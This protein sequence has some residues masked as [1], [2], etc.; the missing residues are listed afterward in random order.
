MQPLALGSV[1]SGMSTET[2]A[3]EALKRALPSFRY[4]VKLLCEID[5]KK[6]RFLKSLH[7]HA[8]RYVD[9]RSLKHED[10]L[11]PVDILFAG[12]S[13]K[14]VSRLNMTAESVLSMKGS[15]GQTL[16]GLNGYL[17][18]LPFEQRPRL[19]F[20]ETWPRW[21]RR[22]PSTAT[23]PLPPSSGTSSTRSATPAIGLPPAPKTFLSPSTA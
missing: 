19:L 17:G 11:P 5:R 10:G 8:K 15:T 1:C 18:A 23:R 21:T 13:C 9:V 22:A 3:L 14:S 16:S 2:V 7:P 4:E 6:L 20:L 12:I